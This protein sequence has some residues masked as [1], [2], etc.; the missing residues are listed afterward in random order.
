MGKH[1][2]KARKTG[3]A[4]GSALVNKARKD[5]KIGHADSYLYTTDTSRSNAIDSVIQQNALEELMSM[6]ELADRD[7]AADRGRAVVVKAGMTTSVE[8]AASSEE[9]RRK[10]EAENQDKLCV[11]RRPAWTSRTTADE[12]DAQERAYFL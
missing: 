9:A 8:S 11:P 5:G 10:A 1:N 6:A 12:L 4:V 3:K 7:F 2:G